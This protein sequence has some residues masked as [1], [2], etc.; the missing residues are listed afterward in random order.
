MTS[1]L[2]D[3]TVEF[4]FYRPDARMVHLVGEF[5]SW[6]PGINPMQPQ[7]DG[8]WSATLALD[9]GEYRFRYIADGTWYTDYASHGIEAGPTGW[10]AVLFI[11][12]PRQ[13]ATTA[14]LPRQ[15]ALVEA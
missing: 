13:P 5:N 6:I 3:G 7:G 1:V 2:G 10:N 11:S 4:R 9:P 8:W 15:R 14:K 12:A